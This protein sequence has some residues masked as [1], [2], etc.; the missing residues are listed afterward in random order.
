MGINR[1]SKYLESVV[2]WDLGAD[3]IKKLKPKLQDVFDDVIDDARHN[4]AMNNSIISGALRESLSQKIVVYKANKWRPNTKMMAYVGINVDFSKA[5]N[6]KEKFPAD[7][8]FAVEFGGEVKNKS[9]SSVYFYEK[10][11]VW[12]KKRKSMYT[13]HQLPANPY[14][15]PAL[16]NIESKIEQ[17]VKSCA[18]ELGEL[19]LKNS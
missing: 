15:R 5:Y 3:L 16:A 4:L 2:K 11:K 19:P 12:R 10:K 6:G 1:T 13:Y 18:N 9:Q 8:A 7:Y 14:L 17:D